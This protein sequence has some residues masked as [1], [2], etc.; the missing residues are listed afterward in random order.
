MSICYN[1]YMKKNQRESGVVKTSVLSILTNIALVAMKVII[2][3]MSHSIAIITDAV[4]NTTDALS[5]I[6]TII[7]AKYANKTADKDHPYGHGRAEYISSLIVS[8]IVLYAG[9]TALIESMKK[10]FAPED[11]DYS[12]ITIVI[13]VIGILAKFILGTYV[14][15]K[16]EK[17]NSGAL[18]AS[19][20]DAF[21]D[22]LLSISVLAAVIIYLIFNVNIEA[23]IG[24]LVSL[25]IIKAGYELVKE[26][27]DSV[28]GKRVDKK[29]IDKIKAEIKKEKQVLGV[30]DIALNDYGP[31]QYMGSAHI[32]LPNNLTV[33]DIDEISRRITK[34]IM[35]KHGVLLHTIGV[36]A[37]D[38]KDPETRKA[39]ERIH[40]I[41]FS[42]PNV[43]EM[44]GFS[45]NKKQKSITFDIVIDFKAKDRD[46]IFQKILQETKKA[47]PK[48]QVS[49]VLD[50]D[51]SVS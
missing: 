27:V 51:T 14:R 24:V 20:I 3:L 32:E 17:I 34:S 4:N 7:G 28:L 29:L 1:F 19:G 15:R 48:H 43:I 26:S 37:I 45:L 21:N 12:T 8:A 44:H 31:D 10:I 46:E 2:G 22:G 9:A 41:V 13:L 36:Y 50:I 6:I 16:G 25:Y 35:Q 11:V 47:F 49:V 30:Y 39:Y 5:S 38:K 23:Y 18:K 42:Y 33:S 40:D